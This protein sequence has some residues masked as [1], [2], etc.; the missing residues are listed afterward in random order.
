MTAKRTDANHQQMI[1]DFRD[2]GFFVVDTHELGRGFGDLV[3]WS[4]RTKWL[5]IEIKSPGGSLNARE[6]QFHAL[7]PGPIAIVR[8][9]DDVLKLAGATA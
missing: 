1:D 3:V 6:R 2:L 9:R 8:T 5:P 4:P 7:C